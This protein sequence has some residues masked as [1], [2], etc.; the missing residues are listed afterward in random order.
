MPIGIGLAAT[1]VISSLL[2]AFVVF[3]TLTTKL[4]KRDDPP[5]HVGR[6]DPPRHVGRFS[7]L[8]ASSA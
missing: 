7:Y 8:S 6:F 1:A 2:T 3:T 4:S 5:R